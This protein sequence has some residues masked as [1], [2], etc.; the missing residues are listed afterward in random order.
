MRLIL[1]LPL[2][3]FLL[4][5]SKPKTVLICGN[6]VCINKAEA[7]QYFEENLSIEV[8]IINKKTRKKTDLVELNLR[9]GLKGKKEISIASKTTTNEN[10]KILSNEEV[11]KI[12]NKIKNK[13]KENKIV[14][15][16]VKEKVVKKKAI[17]LKEE[18]IKSNNN[19]TIQNNVNKKQ[20]EVVDI[21]TILDKCN[22]D[23]IS[24]YL[25]KQGKNQDYPNIT[26]RQ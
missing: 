25:L 16:I 21:C 2:F 14:K 4:N 6:H 7:E 5:C 17:I 1:L 19:K 12:K 18:K 3:L 20:K 8:K 24:K 10:L 13:K 15:K 22:I 23:E 26:T 11:I 9:E